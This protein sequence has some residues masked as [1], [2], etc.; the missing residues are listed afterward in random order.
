MA[1]VQI[2]IH[3]RS[4][5]TEWVFVTHWLFL[6][7]ITILTRNESFL[8]QRSV[9][10]AFLEVSPEANPAGIYLLKINNKST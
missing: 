10:L 3:N 8:W 9:I 7:K 5:R 2:S 1:E 4:A 6:S